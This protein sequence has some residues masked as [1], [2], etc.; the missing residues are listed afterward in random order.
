MTLLRH[1]VG[2][3]AF[4][5][6]GVLADDHG[7]GVDARPGREDGL[8]LA[9]FDAEAADLHLVV[10]A[11][12]ELQPPGGRPAGQVA[13][14]V[15]PGPGRAERVGDEAPG[16]QT[17]AAVVAAGD[18]VARDVQF[19]GGADGRRAQQRVQHVHLRVPGGGAYGDDAGRDGVAG[20]DAEQAAA[21]GGLGRAVLVEDGHPGV[22]G[23]P[24]VQ[25]VAEQGLAA[26]DELSARRVLLGHHAQ[27]VQMAGGGLDEVGPGDVG[28][29]VGAARGPTDQF[30]GAA[31]DQ[32]AEHAGRGEVEGDRRV[33]QDAAAQTL[34]LVGRPR[35]IGDQRAV[36]DDD[37]L[38]PPGGARGEDDERGVFGPP[39]HSGERAGGLLRDRGIVREHD[40]GVR[41]RA[42]GLG[43]FGRGD[44]GDRRDVPQHEGEPVGRVG[45]VERQI[46]GAGLHGGE[47]RHRNVLGHRHQHGDIAL[48]TGPQV[49]QVP[50]QP[51][52]AGVEFGVRQLCGA[53]DDG[54]LVRGAGG[55]GLDQFGEGLGRHLVAGGVP[56]GDQQPPLVGV[57]NVELPHRA[58]GFGGDGGEQSGEALGDAGGRVSVEQVGGELQKPVH[59]ALGPLREEERQVELGGGRGDRPHARGEARQVDGEVEGRLLVG[60][61]E[62]QAGLEQRVPGG[63]ARRVDHLHDPLERD[64]L[65]GVGRQVGGPHPA[66]HL[67][68]AGVAGQVRA[69]HEVV[70][71]EADQGRQGVLGAVGDR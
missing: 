51:V 59:P 40:R 6:G 32:R 56:L 26:E 54:G 47:Q 52:G 63:G 50:G 14:A 44:H 8:H 42:D 16:G 19:A 18:E 43:E 69:Q 68:E 55:L 66:Q 35:Q 38:G 10:H 30:H 15:H 33:H 28:V 29:R 46:A 25:H 41:R 61:V 13:R 21:D 36:F 4:V 62:V 31:G 64:V 5:A 58:A 22:P 3:E 9:E 27:Q 17:G 53:V 7:G 37:R 1:D 12:D 60:V 39:D 23:A 24:G 20:F 11:A 49:A 65:V 34:V 70:G 45:R 71:E 48:R 2:D 67:G 57:H